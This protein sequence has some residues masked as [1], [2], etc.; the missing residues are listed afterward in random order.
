MIYIKWHCLF[1][2][3]F[4]LYSYAYYIG[5]TLKITIK[6]MNTILYYHG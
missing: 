3:N 2:L 1:V 4:F 6:Y 5:S